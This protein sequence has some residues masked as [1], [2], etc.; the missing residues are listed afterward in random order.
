MSGAEHKESSH[1]ANAV[2]LMKAE[3][4]GGDPYVL[5]M[6]ADFTLTWLY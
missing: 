6:S 5:V 3:K 4:Q 1:A 2:L